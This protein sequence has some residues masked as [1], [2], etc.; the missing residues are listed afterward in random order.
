VIAGDI[1]ISLVDIELLKIKVRLLVASVDK[2]MEIGINWWESDPFLSSHA[3]KLEEEN[4]LLYERLDRLESTFSHDHL[5]EENRLLRD[6]LERLE[7]ALST[8]RET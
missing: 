7:F 1:S 3:K 5:I 2:A 6:R 4:R 8:T